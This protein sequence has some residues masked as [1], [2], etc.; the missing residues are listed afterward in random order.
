MNSDLP[1]VTAI[2]TCYN[3]ERFVTHCLESI[4]R[5][6]YPNLQVLLT[7]DRSKDASAAIIRGWLAANP[8][9]PV[10]F[11][12]NQQNQ[13]L[14]KTVNQVLTLARGKYVCPLST[15]DLWEP[16]KIWEQVRLMES[17]PEQTGV[18]YSDAFLMDEKGA[19][20]PN[21]FIG[22][23]RQFAR[24]PEGDIH[25]TLWDG[26]FIPAMTT[27]IR[28]SAF[29][30]VGVYDE[31]LFYE[32]WDMWLRISRRYHFAYFPK[33]SAKYRVMPGSMS[34]ASVDRMR[35]ADQLMFTKYLLQKQVPR[36]ILN[37]AFNY[38]AKTAFRQ[39]ASAP[40]EGRR[41]LD[42]VVRMY[43]S[44]RLIYGWLLYVCGFEYELYEKS[45]EF[46]KRMRRCLG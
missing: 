20:L 42:T 10:T 39:R 5:Q 1:L 28:R 22:T 3:H 31:T 23:Y 21:R 43:K 16:G 6:E 19:P 14:C 34:K 44:P 9:L 33:P 37:K 32:D 11:I 40:G 30:Q 35:V 24:P 8:S 4:K 45:L 7:D 2:V 12:E 13:G 15:D 29:D 18:V 46:A 36:R 41:L 27:L 38:A 26:N 17:L 25:D